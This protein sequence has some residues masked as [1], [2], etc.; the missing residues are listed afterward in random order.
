M[1]NT[2]DFDAQ[3]DQ[4]MRDFSAYDQDFR[5]DFNSRFDNSGYT[6]EQISPAYEYGYSLANDPRFRTSDWSTLEPSVRNAWEQQNPGTW[7]QFKDA[8]RYAWD[9]TR[10]QA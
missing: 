10:G 5:N 3:P 6:F 1:A 8:V 9:R 4:N 7:E 2:D